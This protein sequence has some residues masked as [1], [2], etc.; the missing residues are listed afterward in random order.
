MNVAGEQVAPRLVFSGPRRIRRGPQESDGH[1]F[2]IVG[3]PRTR[4][5]DAHH[6]R[7]MAVVMGASF[8][9]DAALIEH[10]G[11]GSCSAA[12]ADHDPFAWFRYRGGIEIQLRG[13]E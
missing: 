10:T 1:I 11:H 2:A 6:H 4:R 8:F 3:S 13:A 5:F 12:I 7:A 9:H